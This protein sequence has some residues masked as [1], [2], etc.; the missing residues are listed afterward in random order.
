M[1]KAR[2]ALLTGFG[3]GVGVMYFL[4]PA[5][6]A[7]RRAGV[8]DRLAHS[9]SRTRRAVG[10]VRRDIAHRLSGAI[11]R[12]RALRD[13]SAVDDR[14]LVERAR[15]Q[16]GRAVSH[17]HAISVE[18]SAGVV[19]LRGALV[20]AEVSRLLKAIGRVHG[21]RRVINELQVHKDA[22]GIPALQGG[23]AQPGR[24][25]EMWQGSWSPTTRV[26]TGATATALAG[27]GASQRT[28]PGALLAATGL[29]LFARAATNLDTRRLIGIGGRRGAVTVHKM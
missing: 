24:R 22:T 6:G 26:V 11:A 13:D 28:L 4:D 8:R 5:R 10:V 17:P 7:R 25:A 16:L 20:Q 12:M 3:V 27:Y 18:A 19:R 15:A 14:I 9:S 2:Q 23:S 21:V 29:G 1:V